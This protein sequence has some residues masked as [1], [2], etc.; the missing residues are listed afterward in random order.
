MREGERAGVCEVAGDVA[1]VVGWVVVHGGSGGGGLAGRVSDDDGRGERCGATLGS[2]QI[3]LG[4]LV[5]QGAGG[6]GLGGR[7]GDG[8]LEPELVLLGGDAGEGALVCEYGGCEVGRRDEGRRRLDGGERE[9]ST[10]DRHFVAHTGRA[11]N[12]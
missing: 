11:V 1:G 4:V 6:S 10:A 2:V 5:A 8:V 9:A 12:I 7:D 3:P